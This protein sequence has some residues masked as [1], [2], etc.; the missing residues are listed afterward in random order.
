[1]NA[2]WYTCTLYNSMDVY[3]YMYVF[4]IDYGAYIHGVYM[5]VHVHVEIKIY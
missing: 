3:K 5:Y 1:M 2:M 4:T